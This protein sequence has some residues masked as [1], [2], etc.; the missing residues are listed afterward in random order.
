M[1]E[2]R[3]QVMTS[4]ERS[5]GASRPIHFGKKA[6]V[7]GAGRGIGLSIARVL[8]DEGAHV[9]ICDLVPER[10]EAAVADLSRHGEVTGEICDVSNPAQVNR[11]V[12]ETNSHWGGLD[13]VVNNAGIT[14][15]A[16][17]LDSTVEAWDLVMAVN[18]RSQFLV[19][20]AASRLM[21]ASGRGGVIVNISSTN[22]LLGEAGLASYNASK[23]GSLLLTKTM[24]IELAT[25][26]IRVNAVCPGFILTDLA[27]EGGEDPETIANYAQNIPMGRIGDPIEVAHAVSFLLSDKASFITGTEIVVDGGQTCKE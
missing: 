20:Q 5:A 10:V 22:G 15:A 3:G 1:A 6:L 4:N 21:V 16:P 18:L 11:L 13:L 24:A 19:G 2:D 25:R 23:A 27:F 17:F 14:R 12:A 9:T 7:T 26:N 8:L